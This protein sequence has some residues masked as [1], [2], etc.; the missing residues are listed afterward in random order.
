VILHSLFRALPLLIFLFV[1]TGCTCRIATVPPEKLAHH[2]SKFGVSPTTEM[3]VVDTKK[4]TLSIVKDS[5]AARV[6]RISTG[7]NGLG[8]TA[9]TFKT[10]LGLHRINEKIG[11][12]VP[13]YGIFQRRHYVGTTWK[14]LPHHLKRKDYISTRILRL[15]G[16]QPG[17]NKGLDW[18]GRV[19][20]TEKRAVYIHGT[21]LENNIGFPSTKGCV[22]MKADDV[23]SLFEQVPVGTLVWIN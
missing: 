19:V 20:D 7:R 23:I 12:G 18:A 4:Q 11:Q 15:E 13:K 14:H 1:S 10:P 9:N 3:I 5:K 6:Y 21:V 16:L 2:I 22:H 17:F 8:Q